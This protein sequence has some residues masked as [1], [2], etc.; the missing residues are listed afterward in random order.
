MKT[1]YFGEVLL[2]TAVSLSAY[3]S[4][5]LITESDNEKVHNALVEHSKLAVRDSPKEAYQHLSDVLSAQKDGP[6]DPVWLRLV[7]VK[8]NGYER[9]GYYMR[10]LA[11]DPDR[12]E[13]Y[14]EIATFIELAP[15]VF[16]EEVKM[17]YLTDMNAISGVRHDLLEKYGLVSTQK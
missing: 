1:G 15:K 4:Y 16:H 13:T 8:S 12:E 7:H 10:I 2:V 9:L 14:N 11:G 5:W 3:F 6:L 17:D